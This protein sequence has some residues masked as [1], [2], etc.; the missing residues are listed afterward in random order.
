MNAVKLD[1]ATEVLEDIRRLHQKMNSL[2]TEN[3]LRSR[4]FS[5]A[6]TEVETAKLWLQEVMINIQN[7]R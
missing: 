1:S 4:E 3:N 5:L 7:S 6:I 2:N